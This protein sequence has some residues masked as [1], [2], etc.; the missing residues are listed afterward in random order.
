MSL[1]AKRGIREV[2]I[3]ALY[4][5]DCFVRSSSQSQGF[6]FRFT[7]AQLHG[8]SYIFSRCRKGK[9]RYVQLYSPP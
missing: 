2:C 7:P 9:G 3:T 8:N 1:R 6:N 4:I 5:R